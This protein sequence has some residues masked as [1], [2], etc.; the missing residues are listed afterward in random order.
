MWRPLL[1][2][3]L[4]DSK[5]LQFR[6][7]GSWFA[8]QCFAAPATTSLGDFVAIDVETTGLQPSRQRLIEIAIVRYVDGRPVDSWESLCNPERKIPS[9]ITKLTK[10]DNELVGDAPV[11][12]AIAEAVEERLA[13]AIVVGHNVE[14]DLGF[15]NEELKRLG[16]S[17]SSQ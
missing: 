5:D 9:Y 14:F 15:I 10:I 1:R 17:S 2:N 11:F 7:D 4:A 8:P 16:R 12:A 13:G 6:A 3:V